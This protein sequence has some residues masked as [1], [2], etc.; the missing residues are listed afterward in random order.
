MNK[1][2]VI[3]GALAAV[4][5]LVDAYDFSD[6]YFSKYATKAIKVIV[7]DIRES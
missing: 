6:A 1:A 2:A 4:L 7:L 3:L 5:A